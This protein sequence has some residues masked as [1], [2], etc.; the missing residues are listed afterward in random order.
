MRIFATI[1]MWDHSKDY[2]KTSNIITDTNEFE[3][4][5]ILKENFGTYTLI[6]DIMNYENIDIIRADGEVEYYDTNRDCII[7]NDIDEIDEYSMDLGIINNYIFDGK[8]WRLNGYTL[9]EYEK[10]F[11]D[12]L[13]YSVEDD[14]NDYKKYN[15]SSDYYDSEMDEFF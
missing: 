1:S 11:L 5:Q 2:Y 10:E 8:V 6:N 14:D 3:L 15:D 4:F 12:E 9:D 7:F 13:L